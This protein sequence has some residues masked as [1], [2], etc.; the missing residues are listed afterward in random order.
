MSCRLSW[1]SNCAEA[2]QAT[3]VNSPRHRVRAFRILILNDHEKQ[4]HLSDIV[5]TTKLR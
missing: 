4:C 2:A 3:A 5:Q 1:F